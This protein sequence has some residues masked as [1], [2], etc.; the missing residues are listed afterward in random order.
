MKTKILDW[1]EPKGLLNPDFAPKQFIK[2]S[3]EVG[4][5][6]NAILKENKEE[7]KDALGD[8]RIV[9]RI[10][11]NQLGFDIDDCEESAYQVIK[12]RKGVTKNGTFIKD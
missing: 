7:Q 12:N 3:E 9:V 6:A 1:A 2:L 5:L 8:I 4:E 10:L 11:A